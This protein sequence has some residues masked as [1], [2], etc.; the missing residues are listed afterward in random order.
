MANGSRT[1][2]RQSSARVSPVSA[3]IYRG[4][5]LGVL[6]EV[7]CNAAVPGRLLPVVFFRRARLRFDFTVRVF[8][9]AFVEAEEALDRAPRVECLTRWVVLFCGVFCWPLCDA[10]SLGD[11]SASAAAIATIV[12][13]SSFKVLRMPRP[14]II[15]IHD[16]SDEGQVLYRRYASARPTC[17]TNIIRYM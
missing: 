12:P 15:T 3:R 5:V 9:P 7:D 17:A 8:A 11:A 1:V 6:R 14:P 16:M 2:K 10:A 13:T 4:F